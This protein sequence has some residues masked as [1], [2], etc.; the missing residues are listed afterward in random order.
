LIGGWGTFADAAAGEARGG[1]VNEPWGVAVASDGSVY[2]AD[3]WNHR[4]QRFTAEGEFIEMFGFFGQAEAPDAFWGPR[5]VLVDPAGRVFVMDTGNK[6]VVIFSASGEAITE[7]GGFGLDLGYMDEP[8][9]L[10]LDDTGRLF[11]ADTWNQRIQVFEEFGEGNF[12]A[13]EEWVID[14][15]F[16][17]SLDN[18]PYLA[19]NQD[20]TVCT[21]DPEGYRILCFDREGEFALG[22]GGF[23]AGDRDFNLPAGLV[24]D[25]EGRLW[26]ADS[27]NDRIM[28]FV[29]D[30]VESAE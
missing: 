9:G 6:R 25:S 10:A 21:S 19:V 3:T 1:T 2:V 22:W 5:D 14:G 17:Q 7:F 20:G 26:V 30:A 28:R 27:G 23:G 15:W 29:L 18:K 11:V 24:F 12:Q 8:V 4:V 13:T 16:G